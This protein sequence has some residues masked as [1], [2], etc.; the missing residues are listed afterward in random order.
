MEA[1]QIAAGKDLAVITLI[2]TF[3]SSIAGLTNFELKKILCEKNVRVCR[4]TEIKFTVTLKLV[5]RYYLVDEKNSSYFILNYPKDLDSTFMVIVVIF[6]TVIVVIIAIA[7][8]TIAIAIV[9]IAIAIVTIAIAIVTIA[10][11]IVTIAIATIAIAIAIVTIAIATIAIAI[12]KIAIAI[13]TIAIAIVTIARITVI[14]IIAIFTIIT[15]IVAIK[16]INII[17]SKASNLNLTFL[18]FGSRDISAH[19]IRRV[20]RFSYFIFRCLSFTC[21]KRIAFILCF[22]VRFRSQNIACLRTPEALSRLCLS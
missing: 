3:V 18:S 13:A 19:T 21:L 4:Q 6:I 11:A 12:V 22:I 9:T 1:T 14:T 15:I 8:V 17:Q 10:I 16:S 7:I 20:Q 2:L 5:E